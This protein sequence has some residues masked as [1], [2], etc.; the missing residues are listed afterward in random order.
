MTINLPGSQCILGGGI[1]AL[2]NSA[3]H[4]LLIYA[5]RKTHHL[6][7]DQNIRETDT[8]TIL[9]SCEGEATKKLKPPNKK[10]HKHA[11]PI[12]V[13]TPTNIQKM[14]K[15]LFDSLTNLSKAHPMDH[16]RPKKGFTPPTS[17]HSSPKT[18][19][20]KCCY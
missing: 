1:S 11:H 18:V 8:S 10:K 5:I 9:F 6:N 19:H 12:G 20:L 3:Y 13:W 16:F 2:C 4:Q 7:P 17:Y 15:D 14:H